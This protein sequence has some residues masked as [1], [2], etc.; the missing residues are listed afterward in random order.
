MDPDKLDAA[1]K[2][3]LK[4]ETRMSRDIARDR[5]AKL[6]GLQC[7]DGK[8]LGPIKN[9]T[10][11]NGLIVRHGY[12][13]AE[14]GDTGRVD[15]T[16]SATKSY[17]STC[18]GLAWD[19]GLIHDTH[20]RVKEYVPDYFDSP[21]NSKITWHHLLQQTNEWDGTLWDKHYS[22]DAHTA[23]SDYV[24]DPEEPGSYYEYNDVR[25]NLTA[26]SAL[27]VW[28]KP[29][30]QILRERIMDPIGASN[31]WRWYG[32]D[33]SWVTI[34]GLSMQSVS[35]GGHWGGGLQINSRDHARF[36][37]LFL[38]QGKWEGK[39]L[40]S[41]KWIKKA[42]MPGDVNPVYGYM[43]WL[44]PKETKEKEAHEKLGPHLGRYFKG[45]AET[46]NS[47]FS[48]RGAGGN[49]VWVDPEHDLVIVTR[50]ME[51]HNE[52]IKKV[53]DSIK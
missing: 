8:I 41:E 49:W 1:I 52:F 43:W 5:A 16:F 6:R 7:D 26:L 23:D 40:I 3:A 47:S 36:G 45:L 14:W 24:R 2:F 17:L 9:R 20:D 21:H 10:G 51:E 19:D 48:A 28:R 30:P 13:V 53:L 46:P 50:W 11:V 31:T 25:V 42:T 38:R 33:N 15:M 29:L 18:I 39:Q 32:Y 27:I 22:A 44:N 37:Y 35:G 12:I 4:N 34:D